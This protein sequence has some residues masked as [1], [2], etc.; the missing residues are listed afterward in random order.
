MERNMKFNPKT[1][2]EIK[3]AN[4][5]PAGIYDAE[6]GTAED[7][8][9]AAGNEMIKLDVTV[10]D[11]GGGK[12]FIFDYLLEAMAY[13]LR[14]ASEACGLLDKYAKGTLEA[15][16]FINKTCKVK[17]KIDISKDAK[18]SDKNVIVDY[19]VNEKPQEKK[20]LDNALNDSVP[21]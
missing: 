19:I 14:H 16:D 10:F 7:K 3:A 20:S 11:K 18:Y 17:L 15:D 21:F 5:L 4:L 8:T 1:E 6:I 2:N 12:H 9:S 13:K